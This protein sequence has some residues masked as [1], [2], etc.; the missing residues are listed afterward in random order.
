LQIQNKEYTG[1]KNNVPKAAIKIIKE[2][3]GFAKTS[4][5]DPLSKGLPYTIGYGSTTRANGK[6]WKLGDRITEEQAYDLLI[7]QLEADYIPK[8]EKIPG[9]KKFNSNQRG[10][11]LS[12]AYNLGGNFY[13]HKNFRT[14]THVLE[15]GEYDR[16]PQVLAMYRNPGSDCEEGL[17]RRRKAEARLFF[18][19]VFSLVTLEK[20]RLK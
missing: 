11:I 19:P 3:E 1:K 20:I 15:Y 12:F 8:L 4:E 16:L 6:S 10:A 2:F 13:K 17:L 5:P 18:S 7:Y 9:W 14:I